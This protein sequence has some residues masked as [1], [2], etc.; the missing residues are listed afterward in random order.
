MQCRTALHMSQFLDF[1]GGGLIVHLRDTYHV[2][3]DWL[4]SE[5]F[6]IT[7]NIKSQYVSDC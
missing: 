4:L 2:E 5:Y 6:E 1:A 7:L 3:S